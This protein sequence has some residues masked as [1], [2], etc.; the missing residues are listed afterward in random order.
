MQR[1]Y[2]SRQQTDEVEWISDDDLHQ[3]GDWWPAVLVGGICAGLFACGLGALFYLAQN[4]GAKQQPNAPLVAP[5]TPP[6]AV[7]PKSPAPPPS[8]P[9]ASES[10][11]PAPAGSSRETTDSVPP[12][13]PAAVAATTPSAAANQLSAPVS[14]SPDNADD[15]SVEA[16][17]RKKKGQSA[18]SVRFQFLDGDDYQFRYEVIA[19]FEDHTETTSGTTTYQVTGRERQG[20]TTQTAEDGSGTGFVIH[21]DGLLI[22]CAHVVDRATSV[23]VQLGNS[24]YIAEVLEI[25]YEQ[26]LALLQIPAQNLA[27]L[28]LAEQATVQLGQDVRAIGFPLSDV[29]GTGLKVTRGTVSGL[30]TRNGREEIQIDAAVNP[31]NSGGPVVN[32][33]GQVV[34]VASAKLAHADVSGVGFCVPTEQV[35]KFVAQAGKTLTKIEATRE[36]QGP[37]LV[38]AVQPAVAF[39]K[40]KSGPDPELRHSELTFNSRFT[41]TLKNARGLIIPSFQASLRG[42]GIGRGTLLLAHDGQIIRSTEEEQLPLLL[43]PPSQLPLFEFRPGRGQKWTRTVHTHLVQEKQ[44]TTPSGIPLPRFRDPFGNRRNTEVVKVLPARETTTYSIESE[45]DK[46]VVIRHD[47][48]FHTTV[49]DEGQIIK[50]LGSG[51][52]H[53]DRQRGFTS[54]YQF[55]GTYLIESD[56]VTLKV[57]VQVSGTLLSKVEVAEQ[58][59]RMEAHRAEAANL[60][61]AI[62]SLGTAPRLRKSLKQQIPEMGWGVK[63]LAFHPE[64]RFIAAGKNDNYVEIYD[65]EQGRKV[66]SEGRMNEMG[67][68]STIQFSPDGKFLLAGGFKGLIKIWDVAENGLL[69]P[70]GE[71]TGHQ[72]E[73]SLIRF[74]PDGLRVYSAGSEQ[75][76][77][78]WELESRRDLFSLSDFKGRSF[79]LHF[80]DEGSALISDGV[81]LRQFHPVSGEVKVASTLRTTGSPNRVFFSPDGSQVVCAEGYSLKRWRTADGQELPEFKGKETLWDAAFTP[82]GK[83]IIAGGRGHLVVWDTE[84]QV[85]SGHILLGD[86]IQYVKP[87]TL[88]QDGRFVACSPSSA[89]QSLWIFDLSS[90]DSSDEQTDTEE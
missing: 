76:L 21:A 70:V 29:L 28:S 35:Q 58:L 87:L 1:D 89:G 31:G 33:R 41:K 86:S 77:K 15:S 82:D 8:T 65:V 30:L 20:P 19:E 63:S 26:D 71:Y 17:A 38:T 37:E 83:Q 68:I 72:R 69:T 13:A 45:T 6:R 78:C 3:A 4:N 27:P 9:L 48:N 39:I 56:Q 90:E 50:L 24:K 16:I 49:S 25:D 54:A 12:S 67:Q 51:T 11:S 59:A 18:P 14:E 74:S 60:P 88:S 22:T 75:V 40:V 80:L 10:A 47:Y 5:N 42:T 84:E 44:Q 66:F 62:N 43:G 23:E 53:F 55:K 61:D 64:G 85:R 57:P 34:G 36:L 79:G 46:E 52:I 32:S 2:S 73:V 81:S 7:T